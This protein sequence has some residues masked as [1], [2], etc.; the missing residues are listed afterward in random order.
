MHENCPTLLH[1]ARKRAT[2]TPDD[3]AIIHEPSERPAYEVTYPELWRRANA[4]A[5]QLDATG[6]PNDRV[7]LLFPS[8]PEFAGVFLGCLLA[9]R[10]AV[11]AAMPRNER[12]LERTV[13]IVRDSG[14]RLIVTTASML[15]K[16]EAAFQRVRLSNDVAPSVVA[17]DHNASAQDRD[18]VDC[19]A[20]DIAFL[21]YTSGS[22][23]NP[24]GVVVGH[25]NLM[26]NLRRSYYPFEFDKP[27]A[28]MVS[29]LPA[30]HDMGLI[31]G[32]LEPLYSGCK[33]VLMSPSEFIQR[34][35][36]WLELITKHEGTISGGPNF[37]YDACVGRIP[38]RE[39]EALDLSSWRVAFNGSEPIRAQTLDRFASKFAP[40]GFDASAIFPCYGLAE[41]TLMVTGR[42]AREY[43]RLSFDRDELKEGRATVSDTGEG[44]TL[45]GCG[46]P[47]EEH[48][49]VIVSPQTKRPCSEAEVGEVWVS[50]PSVCRGYWHQDGETKAT[51]EAELEG[52]ANKRFLRTGDLGVMHEGQLYI[53][54]RLKNI[55]IIRGLNY[56]CEDIEDLAQASHRAVTRAPGAAFGVEGPAGEELVIAQEINKAFITEFNRA[57]VTAAI[58]ESVVLHHGVRARDVVLVQPRT[59]PR[60]TSGK[61]QRYKARDLY[62]AGEL[63]I[64]SEPDSSG[65]RGA[66][67][68][69]QGDG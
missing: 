46:P 1:V 23:A 68:R 31:G 10:I 2:D 6:A 13:A 3:P 52:L 30:Y 35:L 41:S 51:F 24:R 14:A 20:D 53:S 29:W 65:I 25:D 49:L 50:G 9:R 44:R 26:D 19:G 17:V 55:V 21:Q 32:L 59:L 69:A 56:A 5:T 15:L 16:L 45:V 64:I 39:L 62:V 38:E 11:P 58:Q 66:P 54:G 60:T 47:N 67:G 27:A 42:G 4:I 57:E 63:S 8:G 18:E 7:V 22:T 48:E 12:A 28:T 40:C 61:L 43:S 37:A 36:K 34:P 33:T